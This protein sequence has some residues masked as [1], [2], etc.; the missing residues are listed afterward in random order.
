[1]AQV[2]NTYSSYDAVG[3]REELQDAIFNIDP[4]DTPFI[5]TI[6]KTKIKSVHPEWQTD[7]LAAPT[8]AN[9]K[10]EGDE[11]TYAAP[12]ATSRV[13][14]YTQISRKDLVVSRTQEIVDKAG[15]KSEIAYQMAKLGKELRLDME[16]ALIANNASVA[17]D[18]STP[19]ELGGF[20]AWLETNADRG[21]GGADGGYNSGTGIVDAATDGS[22]RAF[23][24]A[25]L[26]AAIQSAYTAGGKPSIVMLSPYNK[27][28]FSTFM[29][30]SNVSAFRTKLESKGQG[31]IHA[32][33]DGY[34]SDFGFMTV[35]PNRQMAAA[36]SGVS[37]RN[38]F[39]IDPEYVKLGTLDPIKE[40]T[41]AKTGDADKRVLLTEYSL[42]V[43][44]EA[45]HF[46]VADT[47]GLTA[48]S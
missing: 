15:R 7:T 32:A 24:K 9:A 38:V 48:T 27:R 11:F 40:I 21:S 6:G 33:A 1:M 20:A 4:S 22:Q 37:A 45:A 19:R 2:T 28:V 47:Y 25:L 17:G 12:V 43:S 3:N 26:D 39:G 36:D 23:T 31:T 34:V 42:I 46:V 16:A 5:S 10:I 30:D 8:A 41:P 35:M 14:N 13:G 29:S 44:N 18:D